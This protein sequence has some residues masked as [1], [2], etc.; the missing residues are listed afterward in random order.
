MLYLDDIRRLLNKRSPKFQ[1]TVGN[2]VSAVLLPIAL[3]NNEPQVLF[4]IRAE[5][6]KR[7]PGE[8]CFPGGIVEPNELENPQETAMREAIEELG[9]AREQIDLLGPLDYFVNASGI[10]IYPFVGIIAE[11]DRIVPNSSEVE[12]V[13]W[14]PVE[15]FLTNPP[16][17]SSVEVAT[18]F[19]EDFPFHLIPPSYRKGW[20][21]RGVSPVYF[22]K[23]GGKVIWG[24][25]AGIMYNFISLGAKTDPVRS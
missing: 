14:V 23:Y 2:L 22:Y 8:V 24:I 10:L 15:Y 21:K 25:T 3:V 7:Q 18:R 9:L 4:E 11:P 19:A 13:F 17:L 20:W 16:S 1:N 12:E 5:H 6:L